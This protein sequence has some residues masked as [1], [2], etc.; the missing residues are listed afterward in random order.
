MAFIDYGALLRINEKFINKN[1]NLF[2]KPSS[3]GEVIGEV[4]YGDTQKLHIEGNYFVI[5]GDKN[6]CLCFYKTHLIIVSGGNAI[7]DWYNRGFNGET[8][9]VGGI[10]ISIKMIDPEYESEYYGVPDEDSYCHYI[11]N[12]GKRRGTLRLQRRYKKANK[13][14][15]RQK[16]GQKFLATWEYN[17]D[18]YEVI[19]GYGIDPSEEMYNDIKFNSYNYSQK[20]IKLIDSWFNQ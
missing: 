19:F 9:D 3:S 16:H 18:K 20:E 17:G 10:N 12:Y 2:M 1:K 11:Y 6:F 8:F 7:K 4:H 15:Y 14:V 13:V 5:A